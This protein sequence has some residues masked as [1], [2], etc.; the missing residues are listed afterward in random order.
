MNRPEPGLPAPAT[1]VSIHLVTGLPMRES[2]GLQ[3]T[4]SV[5]QGR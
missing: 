3:A 5:M 2:N 1:D 4:L